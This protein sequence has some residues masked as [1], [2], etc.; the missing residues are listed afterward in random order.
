MQWVKKIVLLRSIVTL[1]KTWNPKFGKIPSVF[2]LA[3]DWFP[4]LI[5]KA[6][7]LEI[8][9][10]KQISKVSVSGVCYMYERVSGWVSEWASEQVS[11]WEMSHQSDCIY[12]KQPIKFLVFVASKCNKIFLLVSNGNLTVLFFMHNWLQSKLMNQWLV[13]TQS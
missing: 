12:Y 9:F 1:T 6:L 4:I 13:F 7:I 3:L 2:E 10:V 11:K 8:F 5:T